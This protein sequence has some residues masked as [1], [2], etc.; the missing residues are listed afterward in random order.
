[1]TGMF[2]FLLKGRPHVWS[3]FIVLILF[4]QFLHFDLHDIYSLRIFLEWWR[5]FLCSTFCLMC[6]KKQTPAFNLIWQNLHKHLHSNTLAK[7]RRERERDSIDL[8]I[9]QNWI[10]FEIICTFIFYWILIV[11]FLT[12]ERFFLFKKLSRFLFSYIYF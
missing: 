7:K 4:L 6:E 8:P 1:M 5:V 3:D 11:I 10:E 9:K 12:F 2:F